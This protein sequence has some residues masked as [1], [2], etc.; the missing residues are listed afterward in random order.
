LSKKGG[1]GGVDEWSEWSKKMRMDFRYQFIK[2]F[3]GPQMKKGLWVEYA[4]L[5]N[6]NFILVPQTWVIKPNN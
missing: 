6:H 1:E 2:T 5:F 4:R 3:D